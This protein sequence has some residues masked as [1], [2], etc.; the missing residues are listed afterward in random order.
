MREII[1]VGGIPSYKWEALQRYVKKVLVAVKRSLK[2]IIFI[3]QKETNKTLFYYIFFEDMWLGIIYCFKWVVASSLH[4]YSSNKLNDWLFH[5]SFLHFHLSLY[6]KS[7][8]FTF[9]IFLCSFLEST[10]LN[11]DCV[12]N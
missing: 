4:A 5:E 11:G 8:I 1:E 7:P 10:L 6:N 9:F 2:K 3:V 12:L